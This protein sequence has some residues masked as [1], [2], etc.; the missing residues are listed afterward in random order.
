MPPVDLSVTTQ[1]ALRS[2]QTKHTKTARIY[3]LQPGPLW[4]SNVTELFNSNSSEPAQ[5]HQHSLAHP[6]NH[7]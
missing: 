2:S 7:H 1:T 6:P 4:L 5:P 3:F